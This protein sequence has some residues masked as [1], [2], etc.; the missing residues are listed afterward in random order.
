LHHIHPPTSFLYHLLLVPKASLGRTWSVL[1]FSDF[2]E[3]K[4]KKEKSD[5]FLIWNKGS[6]TKS[7]LVIFL[8]ICVL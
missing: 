8:C 4:R 2:V 1:L 3:E 5:I 7:F 6:Y